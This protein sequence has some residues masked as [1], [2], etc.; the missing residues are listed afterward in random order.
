MI[1]QALTSYY[2]RLV[3]QQKLFPPGVSEVNVSYALCLDK[4]GA[5]TQVIPQ[6][7]MT[8][9]K[10]RP[11]PCPLP[12]PVKRSV[13]FVSNFL[14]DNSRFLLGVDTKGKPDRSLMC[15][16]VCKALHHEILDD[17]HNPTAEAIL[18]FFDTWDPSDAANHP[19]LQ[20]CFEEV[21]AGGNLTFRVDGMF[22]YE[23][24]GVMKA[25]QSHYDAYDGEK[26]VCLVT[27]NEDVVALTHPSIQGVRGAQSSGANIVSFNAD[28]F[29]SYGHEQGENAPI[30]RYAAFAYTQALNYLLRQ[31]DF[32]QT[33]GDTTIVCWAENADPGYS[34]VALS[35]IFGI[36]KS[37]HNDGGL[38]ENDIRDAVKKLATG[39]PVDDLSLSPNEPFYILGIS[40]NASRLSIRFFYR[41]TFGE[42]MKNVNAHHE[43]MSIVHS[44]KDAFETLPVWRVILETANQKAR[45]V[46]PS[47]VL[48]GSLMRSIITGGLYPAALLEQTMLR[49]RAERDINRAKAAIIKA[50]YLRNTSEGCPK[51]VL[52]VALNEASTNPAYILGRLFRV[53]ESVQKEAN[54]GI[55]ST[56]KDKYFNSAAA[57]P[58]I[59]FPVLTGLCQKHLRKLD[60]R[61][62]VN[63]EKQ[64]AQLMSA[65]GDEY[66]TRM[67]LPQQGSFYLGYYHQMYKH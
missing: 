36:K 54:P 8:D 24:P 46:E 13:N 9:K 30:G 3:E 38:R 5:L 32:V 33:I 11:R 28:A 21:V 63:Y 44:S 7:V 48:S 56:I 31:R 50:Y 34:M 19:A 65:L 59:I 35:S 51:E 17:V 4:N 26:C 55:N 37:D 41:D 6:M 18:A 61:F 14:W 29:C 20:D 10:S 1:L 12:S 2:E 47:P 16:E 23:D 15:F 60:V 52:T 53:Y 27:G 64:I 57:T 39:L 58:A 67:S 22:A 45:V 25:W 66:P 42:L 62:A 49:I 43:R 40:P